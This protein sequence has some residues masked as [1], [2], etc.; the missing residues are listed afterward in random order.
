MRCRDASLAI[1]ARLGRPGCSY[2]TEFSAG[3]F[4]FS[5]GLSESSLRHLET[6]EQIARRYL[7]RSDL[8]IAL[9]AQSVVLR[10]IG[11]F[12][13]AQQIEHDVLNSARARGVLM[14]QVWALNGM[15]RNTMALGDMAAFRAAVDRLASL[16]NDSDNRLNAS[17]NNY[18]TL[19]HARTFADLLE[20]SIEAATQ[21]IEAAVQAFAAIQMPQ[22]YTSHI[23]GLAADL[24]RLI[25]AVAPAGPRLI[26][27]TRTNERSARKLGRLFTR[28]LP[29]AALAS[30]DL[31]A[32]R[33]RPS[34]AARH[35]EQAVVAARSLNLPY[36]AAQALHRLADAE[37]L[38]AAT[39]DAY[40]RD[41]DAVLARLGIGMPM[42]WTGATSI[43]AATSGRQ[44]RSPSD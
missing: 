21:N 42:N 43:P 26:A 39:R 38:P 9:A 3:N 2:W 8:E 15:I 31:A 17:A 20:G 34:R 16:L 29:T 13:E 32:M 28:C 4:D 36:D 6:A 11:R 7:P 12:Q 30:G 44:P 27:A 41:R 40:R 24:L 25:A 37:A 18:I 35:W 23:C 33:G 10:G 1:A 14:L 5:Q 22:F 19:L